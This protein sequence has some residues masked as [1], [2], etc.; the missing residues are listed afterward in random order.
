MI[1]CLAT[2]CVCAACLLDVENACLATR[3]SSIVMV[4]IGAS[5]LVPIA[6]CLYAAWLDGCEADGQEQTR[7][8]QV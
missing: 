5:T 4:I 8:L 2:D 3:S 6:G 1:A 7:L